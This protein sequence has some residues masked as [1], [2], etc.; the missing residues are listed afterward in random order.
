M[1]PASVGRRGEQGADAS[2]PQWN[3]VEDCV[4]GIQFRARQHLAPLDQR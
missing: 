4:E 3:A 1:T 2:N